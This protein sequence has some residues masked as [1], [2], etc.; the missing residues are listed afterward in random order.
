MPSLLLYS[1]QMGEV[2]PLSGLNWGFSH[3][4][5]NLEDAYI[6][7]TEG[8]FDAN[9]GFFPRTPGVINVVWDDGKSMSCRL[10]GA[11]NKQLSTDGD[12]SFLGHYIRNRIGV[13]PEH[14]I[15]LADLHAY[16]RCDVEVQRISENCYRFNFAV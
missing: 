10:Q 2:Q 13:A 8:F 16:G 7:I 15:V 4:H 12:N 6:A 14:Q 9:P 5:T 1:A 3:G 11:H